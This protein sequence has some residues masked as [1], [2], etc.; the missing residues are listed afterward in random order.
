MWTTGGD[1]GAES[2]QGA[3]SLDRPVGAGVAVEGGT[4]EAHAW[5]RHSVQAKRARERDKAD[6]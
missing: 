4:G 1:A 3:R 6:L 2:Q 5:V